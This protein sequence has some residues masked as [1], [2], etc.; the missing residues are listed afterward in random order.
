ME[1]M[2]YPLQTKWQILINER[3]VATIEHTGINATLLVCVKCFR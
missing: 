1:N 2:L 3:N